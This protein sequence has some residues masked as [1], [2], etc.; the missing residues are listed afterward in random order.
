MAKQVLLDLS[1]L[2]DNVVSDDINEY[3]ITLYGEGGSGKSTFANAL[4]RRLGN[5]ASFFFEPRMKGLGGIKAVECLSWDVFLEYIKQLRK[6]KK[7]GKQVPFDNIIIDSCDSAYSKCTKYVMEE[8]DWE[9]L[10]GDYGARYTAVGTEFK[11]AIDELRGMGFIVTFLTHEKTAE[12]HDVNNAAFEKA[13]PIVAG[14]IQDIVNDHVDFIMYLQKVTVTTDD[15]DKKEMRRLWLK[16]N[17][18]MALKTPLFGLPDYIDYE[19]VNEGVD[20]F[21]SA[22]DK[23]VEVTRKMHDSGEDISYPNEENDMLVEIKP[24]KTTNF[25]DEPVDL[26]ELRDKALKI[27]DEVLFTEMSKA[28]AAKVLQDALG[29]IKIKECDDV[30]KLKAFVTKYD[31]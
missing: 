1:T 28:D 31:N 30:K 9:T 22:F 17:P 7:D 5:S 11:N 23:A 21:I 12:A 15:G 10:Q 16:N 25:D 26:D 29:T 13:I 4:K 27:R 14:Q 24:P 6:L 19:Y 3:S 20:K 2:M 8:N 18:Y